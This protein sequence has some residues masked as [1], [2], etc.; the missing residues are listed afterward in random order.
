MEREYKTI[1]SVNYQLIT[2]TCQEAYDYNLFLAIIG[3]PGWGKTDSLKKFKDAHPNVYIREID[4]SMKPIDVYNEIIRVFGHK[5]DESSDERKSITKATN[6]IKSIKTKS[7]FIIDEAGKFRAPMQES[8]REF[9]D[10]IE[11]NSSLIISGPRSFEKLF[12]KYKMDN[13]YGMLE[14]WSRI[15][16]WIHLEVPT[17]EEFIAIC[18]ANGFQDEAIIEELIDGCDEFRQL[19]KRI[20]NY[21]RRHGGTQAA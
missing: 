14:M 7:L 19:N 6:L 2:Q 20:N 13:K 4:K 17:E 11:G 16:D 3:D 12:E 21:W 9:S 10:K 5:Q 18:I 1:E 8:I 15:D